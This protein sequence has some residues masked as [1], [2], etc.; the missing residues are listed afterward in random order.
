MSSIT[1]REQVQLHS[2][3][4]TNLLDTQKVITRGNARRDR[5]SVSI[6]QSP[7]TTG[8]GSA[9]VLDLEPAAGAIIAGQ[10]AGSL[11][12]VDGGGALVVDGRVGLEGDRPAGSNRQSFDTGSAGADVAT[13]VVGGQVR[14]G[15]VVVGV[16][17]DVLPC[18]VDGGAGADLLEDVVGRGLAGGEEGGSD[19]EL[20]VGLGVL[21]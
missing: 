15:R 8:E 11:G 3:V 4:D 20:H 18:R 16:L 9:K 10:R 19:G 14:H 13:E 2:L 5:E 7:A 21:V 12:E 6:R 1:A 17:A